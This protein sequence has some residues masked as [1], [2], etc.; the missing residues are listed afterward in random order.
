[1]TKPWVDWDHILKVDPDKELPPGVTYD[2]VVSTGTDA[3]EIGGTTGVTEEKMARV[4]E[5]CGRQDIP[6]YIEPSN[7]TNVVH[8]DSVDGYLIPTVLNAGDPA[9]IT[10]MHK[11]WVRLDGDIDWGR[12]ATEAYIVLNPDSAAAVYTQANCALEAA[13][14]A[15]YARVADRMFGQQIVYVEYS[16]TLGDPDTVRAAHDALE[17]ATLF[18]GGGIHDY[19]SAYRMRSLA[20]TIVVGD[21][22]H[23]EGI[24]AVRETVRGAAD[25]ANPGR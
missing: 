19:E 7:L 22:F 21:L 6:V 12:T 25:A 14:V 1:M 15:A 3:I 10:G 17:A 4:V 16:G 2:D 8:L 20:D 18:Y 13:D 23:D 11:E 5:A 9:W 24:D